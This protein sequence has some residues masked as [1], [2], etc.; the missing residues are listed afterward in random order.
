VIDDFEDFSPKDSFGFTS[1]TRAGLTYESVSCAGTEFGQAICPNNIGVTS[2]G[3][4]NFGIAGATTSSILAANGNEVFTI[5]PS[6]SLR[7]LGF[8]VYTINDPGSAN[9]FPGAEN[10]LVSVLTTSGLT[11]HSLIPPAGN[12]GFLGILSDEDILEVTW[13][14]SAGG[15]KNTGIDDIRVSTAVPEPGVLALLGLGLAALASR[16]R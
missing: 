8:D 4:I 10:V 12:F 9:S 1:F 2:P 6:G 14:A 13:R 15:H 3:Y 16:K 5:T 7:S 11:T